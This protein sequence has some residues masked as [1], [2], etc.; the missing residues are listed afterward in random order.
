MIDDGPPDPVET[1]AGQP[2]SV[3]L[4]RLRRRA[5]LGLIAQIVAI[6]VSWSWLCWVG[7]DN[8]GLWFA[9]DASIHLANG[10]FWLDYIEAFPEPPKTYAKA[11]QARYPIIA[12]IKYPPV[13]YL[14]EAGALRIFSPSPSIL[15]GLVLTACLVAS[16]YQMAWLRRWVGREAGYFAA[17]FPMLPDVAR[18][19]HA[20]LLNIPAVTLQLVA[21]YHT[22]SWLER[23]SRSLQ[24]ALGTGA[25]ILATLCYQG[26]MPLLLVIAAWVVVLR[27]FALLRSPRILLVALSAALPIAIWWAASISETKDQISWL[28]NRTNLERPGNWYWYT[29]KILRAFSGATLGL[30]GLGVLAGLS[31]IRWRREV[32][33]SG[34]WCL[35]TYGFLTFLKGKDPRYILPLASPLLAL[36]AVATLAATRGGRSGDRVIAAATLPLVIAGI[37]GWLVWFN[38][39][40]KVG[41]Y[42]PLAAFVDQLADGGSVLMESNTKPGSEILVARAMLE[43]RGFRNRYMYYRQLLLYAG[44]EKLDDL[45]SYG[46]TPEEA[47]A[48]ILEHSGCRLVVVDQRRLEGPDP[49]GDALRA[50]LDGPS[51]T[52]VRSFAIDEPS[53][54]PGQAIVY[55]RVTPARP[56]SDFVI[57][58]DRS[59]PDPGWFRR[60]LVTRP[61]P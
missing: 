1:D 31:R 27:R 29:G 21:L 60:R 33:L 44:I 57:A 54:G 50:V 42:A 14:A 19:S 5:R 2:T 25:A 7:R 56:L 41:G 58:A 53:S 11:Y 16:F 39:M 24:L 26:A 45:R 35:V 17:L 51:F 10:L 15:K 47:V 6:L 55:R 36:A 32:F 22:R 28:N 30:A 48:A 4:A 3:H 61:V 8:D 34:S 13:F 40:Q 18:Y 37:L 23:P 52:P 46:A 38:P 43:D 20:I 59:S 9:R 49:I 12:P